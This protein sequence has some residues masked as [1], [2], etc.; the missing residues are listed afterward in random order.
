[1]GRGGSSFATGLAPAVSELPQ[2]TTGLSTVSGRPR[3]GKAMRTSLGD[4]H[5][6]AMQISLAP[7]TLERGAVRLEPLGPEHLD[8]IAAAAADGELWNLW[9]TGV[10]RP[11]E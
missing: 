7:V 4:R 3:P 11:D 5:P 1:Q 2:G 10:P 6:D 9:F 8:G